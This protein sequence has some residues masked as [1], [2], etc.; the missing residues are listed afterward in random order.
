MRCASCKH[1]WFQENPDRES[2]ADS[3]F[4]V[5]DIVRDDHVQKPQKT[6]KES[7]AVFATLK[8]DF[9]KGSTVVGIGFILV[10]A[11]YFLYQFLTPSMV[12]GQGVAFDQVTIE[13]EGD[14]LIVSGHIVNAM[15]DVRGVPLIQLTQI[16]KGDLEG[17]TKIV[18]PPVATLQ[19]GEMAEFSYSLDNIGPEVVNMRVTFSN[20]QVT[21]TPQAANDTSHEQEHHEDN[22]HSTEHH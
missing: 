15:N 6:K 7:N 10:L 5:D 9:T 21:S 4:T 16:L 1:E 19:S 2:P 20:G 14:D 12:M 22:H 11:V 3:E 17:D 13:R 8:N 18:S